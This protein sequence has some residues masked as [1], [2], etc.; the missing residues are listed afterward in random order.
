MKKVTSVVALLL[1]VAIMVTP[2]FALGMLASS[3]PAS[4]P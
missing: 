3:P 1:A 4:L 2:A